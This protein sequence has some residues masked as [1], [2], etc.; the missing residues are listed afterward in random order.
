MNETERLIEEEKNNPQRQA[1]QANM[2]HLDKVLRESIKPD[3]V[4]RALAH[5]LLEFE[6]AHDCE[7]QSICTQEHIKI[8]LMAALVSKRIEDHEN[9]DQPQAEVN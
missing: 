3:E 5:L 4:Y 6:A 9:K 8:M 1:Y 2:I 7:D